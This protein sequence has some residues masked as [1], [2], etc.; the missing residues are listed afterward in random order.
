MIPKF[1]GTVMKKK[2]LISLLF[3]FLLSLSSYPERPKNLSVNFIG[4][5]MWNTEKMVSYNGSVSLEIKDSIAYLKYRSI[6]RVDTFYYDC[7]HNNGYRYIRKPFRGFSEF[8]LISKDSLNLQV[9]E[10]NEAN[11]FYKLE[12]INTTRVC[13]ECIGRG[14]ALCPRCQ[15]TGHVSPRKNGSPDEAV[16]ICPFCHGT[17]SIT[18]SPCRRCNGTGMIEVRKPQKH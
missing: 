13:A 7:Q 1:H 16:G 10:L 9:G 6:E 4:D 15:G 2:L 18:H 14:V 12:S 3:T 5:K 17:R 11:Y 8:V